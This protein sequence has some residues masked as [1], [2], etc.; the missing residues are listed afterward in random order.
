MSNQIP[1]QAVN[2][3]GLGVRHRRFARGL[4]GW[5]LFIGIACMLVVVLRT[6]VRTGTD[7]PVS[8]F[9]MQLR[10]G[11]VEQVVI[12]GDSV[13]G[14]LIKSV[15]Y[16][17]PPVP[18]TDFSAELPQGTSQSWNFVQWVVDN[19]QG[20]VVRV[21]NNQNVLLNLLLPLIPWALIFLFIW[22]FLFRQLRNANRTARQP[23]PVVIVNAEERPEQ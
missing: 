23:M 5:V 15:K 19:G 22:F 4:I 2:C 17:T 3:S 11:N 20:A 21:D 10:A 13:H 1:T 14:R 6:R 7:V 16:G 12:D 18:V 8:E 9:V